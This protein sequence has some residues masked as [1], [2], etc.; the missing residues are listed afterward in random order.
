MPSSYGPN[1]M[2]APN[3]WWSRAM[4]KSLLLDSDVLIDYLRQRPQAVA[5]LR[6]LPIVPLL[7][8]VV[9]AEL[10]SGVRDG[11]KRT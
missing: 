10:F 2:A 8:A 11:Q 7:S 9:V 4:S 3:A 6:A 5:Y 1:G